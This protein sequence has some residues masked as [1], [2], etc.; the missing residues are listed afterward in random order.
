MSSKANDQLPAIIPSEPYPNA[1]KGRILAHKYN[2]CI[3]SWSD[4]VGICAPSDMGK[5]PRCNMEIVEPVSFCQ[6]LIHEL[7]LKADQP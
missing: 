7:N 3:Y 6:K 2:L 4:F 1:F 5:L